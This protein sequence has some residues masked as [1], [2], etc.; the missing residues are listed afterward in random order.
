M[1]EADGVGVAFARECGPALRIERDA[2]PRGQRAERRAKASIQ[3]LEAERGG[4]TV[5]R[6]HV[7][8][9]PVA[10]ARCP[11]CVPR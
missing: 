6:L 8:T 5:C 11:V 1:D 7:R 3:N 2:L 10:R 9:V 4:R